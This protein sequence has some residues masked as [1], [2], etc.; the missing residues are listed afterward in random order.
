MRSNPDGY[1]IVYVTDNGS[2]LINKL[3]MFYDDNHND[4]IGEISIRK[5][6]ETELKL[7]E[8]IHLV[9][10]HCMTTFRNQFTHEVEQN[11]QLPFLD[12]NVI[13][14]NDHAKFETTVFRKNTF[15]GLMINW[16]SFVPIE[17]KKAAVVS[18]VQRALSICS[19]YSL[20]A[21]E[22]ENIRQITKRNGYP[23]T[24][25]D[26]RIGIGL[27]KWLGKDN[28]KRINTVTGPVKKKMFFELPYVG[29]STDG[30]KRK[31]TALA[32]KMRPDT[33]LCFYSKTPQSSQTFFQLKDKIPKHLQS[34]V[35]YAAK[36]GDCNDSYVGKTERQ[37]LRRLQEHGAPQKLFTELGLK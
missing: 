21:K 4:F 6:I 29:S 1:R 25:V 2:N 18:M 10:F 37:C 20:L 27:T 36:C 5:G 24:F 13:R 26:I 19:S 33:D 8:K 17:Y 9:S 35:V 7:D 34:D 16:S 32:N 23:S 15:T 14:T 31:L 22:F 30:L 12:V 28:S 3:T 11:D